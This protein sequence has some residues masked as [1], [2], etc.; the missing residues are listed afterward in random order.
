MRSPA[1]PLLLALCMPVAWAVAEERGQTDLDAAID[2]KLSAD[3]LD[4]FGAV[5]E[6]CKS[7][8][9]KGLDEEGKKFAAD[10]YTGTLMDRAGMVVDAIF[11]AAN[12]DPQ[13]PRMRQFALRDL[14]EAIG[15][16]PGLGAAWLMIARLESLPGGDRKRAATAADKAIDLGGEDRL[17]AAQAHVIRGNLADADPEARR[18]AY[19]KAVELAPRDEDVRR[20]RGLFHLLNDDFDEARA[21]L[22]VAIEEDPDDVSLLEALGMA[23]MMENRLD[24]AQKVFDKAITIDPDAAGALLQRARVLALRGEQPRAIAD[25]DKAIELS[26]DDAIPLVLRARI[27]QQAGNAEQA[28]ADLESVLRRRPDH[29]AALELRGLIAAERNDYPAAIRDF[30]KLVSQNAD[31]PLLVG[32][33]GMLYLA[34]RQPREAIR[35]FTR[36]L[37]IDERQFLS[38]RGR[39]DAEISIG[40][41]KAALVDLEKALELDG[42]NDGV[43]NNLAW[44]LAT[45]PDDSIRDGRRAIELATKACEETEWKQAHI[46]STLAAGYAESGDFAKAREYSQKALETG[47]ESPEIKEQLANELASYQAEKP[48]RERQE[49]AEA[50]ADDTESDLVLEAVREEEP[51]ATPPADRTPRRPFDE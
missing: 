27:H 42:D 17:Q 13:W 29:P 1:L 28:Q 39:S 12:P 16:D 35:R 3:N 18:A 38:R 33:L 4:D 9:E 37:E 11:Q 14:D 31:D 48:W 22:E 47:G 23:F 8:L 40:D 19:D 10:L 43:L 41:H 7:A 51:A 46:I 44:L 25:L 49:V 2:A 50:K 45:S 34:A 32:Q 20:T 24:E 6:L 30:R 36:A 26:P 21:D 5:L 15:R